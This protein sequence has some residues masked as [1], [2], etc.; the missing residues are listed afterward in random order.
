MYITQ[1]EIDARAAA[2]GFTIGEYVHHFTRSYRAAGRIKAFW[3]IDGELIVS[4][5]DGAASCRLSEVRLST[6]HQRRAQF[7]PSYDFFTSPALIAEALRQAQVGEDLIFNYTG[8]WVKGYGTERPEVW[9]T[10]QSDPR[11]DYTAFMRVSDAPDF[12]ALSEEAVTAEPR[13]P[14]HSPDQ[15]PK[16]NIELLVSGLLIT[17]K[18]IEV[19]MNVPAK[20]AK[21]YF[22]VM[23]LQYGDKP[24]VL[25]LALFSGTTDLVQM[26]KKLRQAESLA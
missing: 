15:H 14:E 24:T 23:Q 19:Q 2:A 13:R 20:K 26:V 3:L 22:K 10:S 12:Y 21:Q 17:A 11:H 18:S 16:Y 4:W 5:M 1:A 6:G 7:G 9:T 8:A 25:H